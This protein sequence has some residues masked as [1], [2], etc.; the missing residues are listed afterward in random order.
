MHTHL[1][2][3][4]NICASSS[5]SLITLCLFIDV[6]PYGCESNAPAQLAAGASGIAGRGVAPGGP[7]GSGIEPTVR[8]SAR[9]ALRSA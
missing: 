8:G 2:R 3:A 6:N 9:G 5:L 7:D 4:F 1:D